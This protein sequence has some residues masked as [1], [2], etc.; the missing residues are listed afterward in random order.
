MQ[1]QL[2]NLPF[3]PL[4][5]PYSFIPPSF[6]LP[7]FDYSKQKFFIE[8][9]IRENCSLKEQLRAKDQEILELKKSLQ[10][11][12]T[13]KASLTNLQL[14]HEE[15][16]SAFTPLK[17]IPSPQNEEVFSQ[18][19]SHTIDQS[20]G[21]PEESSK[22]HLSPH[23]VLKLEN[24]PKLEEASDSSDDDDDDDE[25]RVPKIKRR[26]G[27]KDQS[28]VGSEDANRKRSKAKHL[29]ISYGRKIV[30]YA[31]KHSR[32]NLK[33]KIQK[34][35]NKLKSKKAYTQTFRIIKNKQTEEEVGFRKEFGRL[36]LQFLQT[37]VE[38]AFLNSNY[39]DDFLNQKEKVSN[40]IARQ[41][42][43]N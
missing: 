2:I 19:T 8:N 23:L 25:R 33:K 41:I 37:E 39:R 32:P 29:W 15:T 18:G 3:F 43:D 11:A 26:N 30:E 14:K 20:E 24:H 6:N 40:W 17:K 10:Q 12:S 31:V 27:F 7:P 13:P 1:Q 16:H 4:S 28:T 38:D 42:K 9:L 5:Q 34:F 35:E 36:A 21:T 22:S